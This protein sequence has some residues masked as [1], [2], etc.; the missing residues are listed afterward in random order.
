[1]I[2]NAIK[3]RIIKEGDRI[4]FVDNL[5]MYKRFGDVVVTPYMATFRGKEA[6]VLCVFG[7]YFHIKESDFLFKFSKGMIKEVVNV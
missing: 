2:K 4:V 3:E 5:F 7:D 1:M 6:T